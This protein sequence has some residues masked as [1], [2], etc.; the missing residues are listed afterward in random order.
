MALAG[1]ARKS[2]KTAA[3]SSSFIMMVS[4][5]ERH[6]HPLILNSNSAIGFQEKRVKPRI[7]K[8]Y[9]EPK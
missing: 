5:K 6:N 3:L 2:P 4:S 7:L 1:A 9:R 8:T